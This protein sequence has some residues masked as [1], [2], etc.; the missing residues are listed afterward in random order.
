MKQMMKLTEVNAQ[1]QA[2][3]ILHA[4]KIGDPYITRH[5][6]AMAKSTNRTCAKFAAIPDLHVIDYPQGVH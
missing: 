2:A 1:R 6:N 3:Y 5:I 4:G